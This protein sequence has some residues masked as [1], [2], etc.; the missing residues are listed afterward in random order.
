[1]GSLT[2]LMELEEWRQLGNLQLDIAVCGFF[3]LPAECLPAVT[4]QACTTDPSACTTV[5]TARVILV[6][7]LYTILHWR[8]VQVDLYEARSRER[9]EL[10]HEIF[11][12]YLLLHDLQ[13][14]TP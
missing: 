3:F 7:Q 13:L 9:Q 12:R 4:S 11:M 1:M 5:F 10:V 6:D 14:C 8:Q 2:G